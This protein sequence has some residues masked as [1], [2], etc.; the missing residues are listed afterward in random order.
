MDG[1][2]VYIFGQLTDVTGVQQVALPVIK[3]TGELERV[4]LQQFPGLEGRKFRI[5]VD[6]QLVSGTVALH[7]GAEVALMPPFSGG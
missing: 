6:R 4:L 1:I 3:D 7:A 5:A 2:V